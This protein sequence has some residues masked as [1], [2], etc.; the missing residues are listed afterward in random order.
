M[1]YIVKPLVRSQWRRWLGREYYIVRR[2]L[3]DLCTSP[4]WA[5]RA[6]I[7]PSQLY[8]LMEHRSVIL[9]PLRDVEMYLQEN[10][11]TNLRLAI[12]QLDGLVIRPGETFSVWRHVGR[13]TARKGYLEGLVLSQGQICKGI[14]GGLC[15]LGNLLFWLFAHSPLT[16]VERHRH[17]FDVFPDVNRT[18]PFGAGATLSYNYIDLRATNQTEHTLVLDLWLDDTYL[19]GRLSIDSPIDYEY[20]V[21][22]RDHRIVSQP[23]GG[24][25]RHNRIYQV[26]RYRDG[27]TAERLLVENHAIMMYTPILEASTSSV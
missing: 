3:S 2:H 14:G 5:S 10:K 4:R 9:R 8:T 12:E 7:R 22:E 6:S 13:P 1:D 18:I 16:I 15:Q 26:C 23:W 25:T 27:S 19:Y 11:R 24:Y 17:T 20:R 21:E